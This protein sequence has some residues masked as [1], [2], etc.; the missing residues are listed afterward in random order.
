MTLTLSDF[1]DTID[2]QLKK[3]GTVGHE[4]MDWYHCPSCGGRQMVRAGKRKPGC[5]V[6]NA[7]SQ[8]AAKQ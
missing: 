7:A 4:R 6:R 2:C 8:T 1:A 3:V 5:L